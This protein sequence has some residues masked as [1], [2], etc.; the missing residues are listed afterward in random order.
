MEVNFIFISYMCVCACAFTSIYVCTAHIVKC[1]QSP[2]NIIKSLATG[3][4]FNF[5]LEVPKYF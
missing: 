1:M 4:I 5:Y 2:D 3:I